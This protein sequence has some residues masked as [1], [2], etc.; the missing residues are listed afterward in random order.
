MTFWLSCMIQ[1]ACSLLYSR[2]LGLQ[3]RGPLTIASKRQAEHFCVRSNVLFHTL[4]GLLS[5]RKPSPLSA[6]SSCFAQKVWS[7]ICLLLPYCQFLEMPSPIQK[8][9]FFLRPA[10]NSE[11]DIKAILHLIYEVSLN[12]ADC[13]KFTRTRLLSSPCTRSVLKMLKPHQNSSRRTFSRTTTVRPILASLA[14]ADK[15]RQPKLSWPSMV[16][17][18]RLA[19]PSG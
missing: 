13:V 11:A 17:W 4:D 14:E 10:Q 19:K 15:E 1:I 3:T 16:P 6:K 18:N 7:Q 2:F 12:A 9:G 5:R 8:K